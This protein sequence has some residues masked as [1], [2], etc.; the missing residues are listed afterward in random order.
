MRNHMF[1][2]GMAISIFL[3]PPSAF[4]QNIVLSGT[5][6]NA[7]SKEIVPSVSVAIKNSEAGTFTDDKGK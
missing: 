6:K 4:S 1:A 2:V 5:V 3:L 7:T